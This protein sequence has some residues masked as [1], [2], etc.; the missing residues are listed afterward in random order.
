[1]P[2]ASTHPH[3]PTVAAPTRAA[4]T[5]CTLC[6][7]PPAA[8]HEHSHQGPPTW[9][10]V[11]PM[12]C[13][14]GQWGG[15]WGG[16]WMWEWCIVQIVGSTWWGVMCPCLAMVLCVFCLGLVG[17]CIFWCIFVKHTHC[18]IEHTNPH[19]HDHTHAPSSTTRTWQHS[20]RCY[21][22]VNVGQHHLNR[23]T[24]PMC[25]QERRVPH[26]CHR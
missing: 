17:M 6:P 22:L 19:T 13:T 9:S 4:H 5:L 11:V 25:S 23:L 12:Q 21:I 10:P 1:M 15:W 8:V 18:S 26:D 20:S 14:G 16:W 7:I 24:T 3:T 2:C